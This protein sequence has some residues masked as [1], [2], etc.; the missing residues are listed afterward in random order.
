MKK[1]VLLAVLVLVAASALISVAGGALGAAFGLGFLGSP[2]PEISVPGEKIADIGGYELINS[3][4]LFWAAILII[5]TVS[6]LGTR[7]MKMVPTGFQNFVEALVE[8]FIGL[9]ESVGGPSARR[10]LPL[11]MTIFLVVLLSN[12]LGIL[13]GVGTIGRI[14][15]AEELVSHELH[16]LEVEIRE[17]QP[18]LNDEEVEER[19][20]TEALAVVGKK[21][22]TVFDD[23]AG[24]N[25]IPFGRG[26]D[27]KA[28]LINVVGDAQGVHDID[29]RLATSR[30]VNAPLDADGDPQTE[31]VGK[32]AGILIPYL[33]GPNTDLN[34][35]LAIALVAMFAIQFWGIRALGIRGYGSKFINLKNGPIHFAVGL[36][37]IVSELSRIISFTFRLFG[38]MFAGEV[39][40]VVMAFLFPL[41]GIIPFLGLELFV[42]AIQAFIFA[43][44]TLVFAV[45][46]T[47]AHGHEEH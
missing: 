34:T 8:G 38:N 22:L 15:S 47:S 12:W 5:I 39:L 42:G 18:D 44:L 17:S 33:R 30:L 11:V 27:T 32:N 45:V 37:E 40:L 2:I 28:P 21:K 13:P 25:L 41:I 29:D 43:M 20:L 35:T 6:F 23:T 26:E 3:S 9:V 46:A 31:L 4:I 14:E 7:N 36:L 10:F 1:P 24:I 16:D 19:A